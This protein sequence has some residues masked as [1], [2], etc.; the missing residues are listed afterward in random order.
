[1]LAQTTLPR[2]FEHGDPAHPNL[3]RRPDGRVVA[4]DWERGEPDGLPLHDLTIA[5]AYIAAAA[6]GATSAPDQAAAF[7]AAM[8]GDDPWAAR[9]LDRAIDRAGCP[10]TLRPALVVAAWA[11]TA[12]WLAVEMSARPNENATDSAIEPSASTDDVGRWLVD[13][14]SVALWDV[15]LDLAS[16]R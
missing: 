5:L 4:V 15:S 7:R 11:R 10:T 3:L 2:V 1:M 8:T 9:A 6:A 16:A 12:A 14:R 13:D